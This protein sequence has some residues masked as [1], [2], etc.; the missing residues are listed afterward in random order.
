MRHFI[1]ESQEP[2]VEVST[3]TLNRA[4]L[5]GDGIFETMVYVGGKIRFL[6]AHL[7]RANHGLRLLRMSV[8][9]QLKGDQILA[10]VRTH[11]D[12]KKIYRI[13]WTLFRSGLGKYTPTENQLSQ[14]V[15]ISDFQAAPKVKESA[16][17]SESIRV[18]DSFWSNCKTINALPYVLAN[19]ERKERKMDEV[20]LLD[21][22]GFLSEAGSSNLFWRKKRRIYTPS[23]NHA[24]IAGV[25]RKQILER[26]RHLK[27]KHTEG[28]FRPDVLMDAD[29]V[30]VSNI[31]G[32][33]YLK[34][35]NGQ[36]FDTPSIPELESLFDLSIP[37]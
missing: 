8:E 23:L 26:L 37:D 35:I 9:N 30:F 13:R 12:S 29:Q 7:N 36:Q 24:C 22:K 5:F 33:S 18:Y 14:L 3:F 31:S 34:Q 2:F 25:G 6:N 1:S 32:I 10:L 17:I 28:S 27:I 4:M 15:S 21:S 20:I 19:L 16:Y 11:F